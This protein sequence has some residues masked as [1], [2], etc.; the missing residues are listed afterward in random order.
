MMKKIFFL[1]LI[2]AS[3]GYVHAQDPADT[4]VTV[5]ID[6][7]PEYSL[8][9]ERLKTD[10]LNELP[11]ATSSTEVMYVVSFVVNKDGSVRDPLIE[12]NVSAELA[13]KINGN[14]LKLRKFK[15]AMKKM[16]PVNYRMSV[17]LAIPQ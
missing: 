11:S 12:S 8:G 13:E 16:Q 5:S 15:P 9:D 7:G 6:S 2:L 10:L 1:L 17:L 4:T 14:V 3:V